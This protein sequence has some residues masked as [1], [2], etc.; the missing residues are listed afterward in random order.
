MC[1]WRHHNKDGEKEIKDKG[2]ERK[3]GRHEGTKEMVGMIIGMGSCVRE[4]RRE[5]K[6]RSEKE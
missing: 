6:E 4:R 3:E 5:G 2:M 1:T